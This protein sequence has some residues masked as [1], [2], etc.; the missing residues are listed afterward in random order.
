[1]VNARSGVPRGYQA[2]MPYLR[3]RDAASAIKFYKKVFGAEE[4]FRLK[5]AGKVGH[6]ELVMG[7]AVVMLSDEFP[8]ANAVGPQ[9]LRGTSVVMTVYVDDVDRLVAKAVK[10]GA[11]VR[12]PVADQF[13]G[14]R[15]GQIEDPFGHVWS[16]Q[17]R[18]ERVSPKEMQKRLNALLRA[19]AS[20]LVAKRRGTARPAGAGAASKKASAGK[21]R[22][23]SAKIAVEKAPRRKAT[24]G[25]ADAARRRSAAATKS[26]RKV[27]DKAA[28]RARKSTT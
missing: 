14:D 16:I 26:V 1:M 22:R 24:A 5:M 25:K 10:A 27:S 18:V 9:A 17:T 23:T 21:T 7:G 11:K 4:R 12:R 20:A 15:T 13:Y 28:R 8:E 6:A 3:V 2:V 19:E